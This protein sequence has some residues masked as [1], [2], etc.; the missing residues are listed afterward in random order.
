MNKIDIYKNTEGKIV[1]K[2]DN[3]EYELNYDSFEKLIDIVLLEENEFDI[4]CPEE[5]EEYQ[6]L[7]SGIIKEV[8]T[9]DFKDAVDAANKSNNQLQQAENIL[10]IKD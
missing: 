8:Q 2:L 4:Q 6:K 3:V 1:F 7:I 5:L 10:R 9:E